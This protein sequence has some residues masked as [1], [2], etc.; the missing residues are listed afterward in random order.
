[1]KIFDHN[2]LH[3]VSLESNF[4]YQIIILNVIFYSIYHLY[5]NS[6]IISTFIWALKRQTSIHPLWGTCTAA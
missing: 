4:I 2:R 5:T 1:M 3:I 6:I